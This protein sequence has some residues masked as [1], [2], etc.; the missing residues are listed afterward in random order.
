MGNIVNKHRHKTS[1]TRLI[2]INEFDF[3][4]VKLISKID[5]H[6]NKTFTTM[7]Y[8]GYDDW[9]IMLYDISLK[10][11]EQNGKLLEWHDGIL[12]IK[13]NINPIIELYQYIINEFRKTYNI[14]IKFF[15]DFDYG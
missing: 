1:L 14:Q 7:K 4:K 10:Y 6:S 3:S 9:M 13:T 8:D 5:K 11:D 12:E 15:Y 2:S